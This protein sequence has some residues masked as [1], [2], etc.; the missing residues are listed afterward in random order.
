MPIEITSLTSKPTPV[1][2]D[3]FILV[4]SV[5][6]TTL[7][8]LTYDNIKTSLFASPSL[9]GTP[10]S[11]TAAADTNTTQI[12]TT[13]YVIGQ[14]SATTPAAI[15]T[16]N[17]G[18]S[19]KYARADHVH[20]IN[21]IKAEGGGIVVVGTANPT[22]S[23]ANTGTDSFISGSNNYSNSGKNCQISGKGNHSNSGDGCQISGYEADPA[24]VPGNHTNSGDYC[25]ISG[26]RNYSNSGNGCQISGDNNNTNTGSY[27]LISG[28][29]NGNNEGEQCQISGSSNSYNSGDNCLISGYNNSS[30][31]GDGCFISG[32]SNDSNSGDYC[33]ISGNSASSNA[34]S[35]AR[36]HGG[37]QFSRIIDVVAKAAT[38]NATPT[39]LTLGGLTE[40]ATNRINIP[41]N[42][43]WSFIATIVARQTS[44]AN[45]KTFT[46]RGLI[47]NNGGAVTISALDTI[48]TDHVLGTLA[49]TAAITAD[50]T[51][52]ALKIVGT[53]IA[54]TNIKWTA[55]VNITQVG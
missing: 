42:S 34:L 10:L 27:C 4:D 33:L 2:A 21:T 18:T 40:D 25:L 43:T 24:Y 23:G 32:Y 52:D 14:A 3:S 30:N 38:T 36:V 48:G 16:A 20:V 55:Q 7:K 45:A 15:G 22:V 37:S 11:T 44:S 31:S 41:A 28:Y 35:Y 19:L 47:G 46:R 51:N 17:I 29:S 54:A 53:G 26:L 12:A 6:T 50:D 13:A 49:V 1:G 9:T 5:G 39:T 8:K